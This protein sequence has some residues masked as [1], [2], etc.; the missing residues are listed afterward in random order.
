MRTKGTV[1]WFN[2][3]KG[4]GFITP[5]NGAKDCFVHFSAIS[6]N[7]FKSLAE[8]DQVE[9]DVIDEPKGPKAANVTKI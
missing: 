3:A 6:G 9:F 1:K 8:G 4:F 7:G 5:E 2:D